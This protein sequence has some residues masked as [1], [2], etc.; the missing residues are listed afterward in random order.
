MKTTTYLGFSLVAIFATFTQISFAAGPTNLG[1][2]Y[3]GTLK[4]F[5]RY[6]DWDGV[7]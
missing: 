6:I 3:C 4:V 5:V 7:E 1:M 2:I